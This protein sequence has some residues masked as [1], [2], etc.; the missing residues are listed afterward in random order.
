M[1]LSCRPTMP[2]DFDWSEHFP[3]FFS[4]KETTEEG[5]LEETAPVVGEISSAVVASREFPTLHAGNHSGIILCLL[6]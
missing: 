5:V 4:Q 2:S 1:E 6:E 3:A